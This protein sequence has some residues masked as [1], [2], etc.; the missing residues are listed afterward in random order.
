MSQFVLISTV[1]LGF[2]MSARAEGKTAKTEHTPEMIAEYHTIMSLPESRRPAAI[3]AFQ[4]KHGLVPSEPAP[5]KKAAKEEKEPSPEVKAEYLRI[6]SLPEEKR[7][8]A[9]QEF[10]EAR[11]QKEKARGKRRSM[12]D[13][14][15]RIMELPEEKRAAALRK[16]HAKYGLHEADPKAR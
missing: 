8:E 5:D 7:G 4:K 1:V 2:A 3:D 11:P 13:D 16:M 15:A 14:Y 9:L 6:K 12:Q 10:N